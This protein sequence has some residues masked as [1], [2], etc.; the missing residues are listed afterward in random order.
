MARVRFE[1]AIVV[2]DSIQTMSI[3]QQ[4]LLLDFPTV[5]EFATVKM[6]RRELRNFFSHAILFFEHGVGEVALIHQTLVKRFF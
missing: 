1:E 5:L 3:R 2:T 4:S 6:F